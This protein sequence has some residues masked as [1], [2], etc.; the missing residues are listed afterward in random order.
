[1]RTYSKF[2]TFLCV[3]AG[4]F[5]SVMSYGTEYAVAIRS[6]AALVDSFNGKPRVFV[7]TDIGNETDDQMSLTR[8]LLYSNEFDVEG[9]VATTSTW[10]RDRVGPEIIHSVLSNYGKIRSIFLSTPRAF[11]RWTTYQ[12]W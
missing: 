2:S 10:Q 11:Q 3:A 4:F 12:A 9:L 8:F 6:Q 5:S 7:L 1:M